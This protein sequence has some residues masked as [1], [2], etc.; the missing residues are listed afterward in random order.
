MTVQ[1]LF[2]QGA[3]EGTHDTWDDK[4]VDS[5]SSRLG[6]DYRIDYPRMPG[7][8]DPVY[9]A[10][11]AALESAF[12]RLAAGAVLIGH[13]AGGTMLIHALAERPPGPSWGAVMLIAAPFMGP[14]G[15]ADE[16]L[17]PL[18]VGRLRAAG[19]PLF[20]YHGTGDEIVP[21]THLELYAKAMPWATVRR[22]AGR[23][24]QLG[25]DLSEVADDVRRL[26]GR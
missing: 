25:N 23:D 20:L 26:P 9:T 6:P 7:E 3:G 15:W 10:W 2:V 12:A 22:L 19:A 18:A 1:M 24:H 14:G 17:A 4:L 13:S 8:A 11:K 21:V 16:H 5:L